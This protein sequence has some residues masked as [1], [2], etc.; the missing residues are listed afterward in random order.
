M[1]ASLRSLPRALR[2]G[3][4]VA[5]VLVVVVGCSRGA[6]RSADSQQ[7]RDSVAR[8]PD[9][10]APPRGATTSVAV[11]PAGIGPL[12][13]GMT[14]AQARA[15]LGAFDLSDPSVGSTCTYGHSTALPA[16]VSVMVE[17]G[18]IARIDV[19]SA[20]VATAKGARVGDR[21]A[22]V[23]QLYEGHVDVAPHKYTG[24]HYLTVTPATGD[25]TLRII[26]ETDGQAVTRYRAGK[27]P[28]VG[29][30]EGCS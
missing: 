20:G 15:T 3:Q 27:M 17:D 19:D 12:H 2:A 6:E 11:T 9:A 21:E 29:Y 22:R 30:V 8:R 16:G 18:A 4:L 23:L 26:F 28:Q 7:S 14:V 25:S 24:G 1:T 10:S 13:I 5:A